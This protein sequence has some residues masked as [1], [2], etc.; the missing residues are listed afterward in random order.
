MFDVEM[1]LVDE[2]LLFVVGFGASLGKT[3][4]ILMLM[5]FDL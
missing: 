2:F 1:D 5:G 3:A 4:V